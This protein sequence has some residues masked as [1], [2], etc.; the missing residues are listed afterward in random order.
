MATSSAFAL[1]LISNRPAAHLA[2][3]MNLF[4]PLIGSWDMDIVYYRSDGGVK[5][6]VRGEWHFTWALEGRAVE[7]VWITPP[8]SERRAIDPA[9]GEYGV[10]LRFFDASID[11]WRSTWHG[12]VH[13][14]VWPFI[15]RARGNDIVLER[16]DEDGALAHWTF[17]NICHERFEWRAEI[18]HDGGRT[19]R[20][21]QEMRARRQTPGE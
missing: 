1:A 19:W 13:G 10:T 5:S 11:A 20:L 21:E 14:I 3:K 2:D 8:R 15:G 17:S 12:P 16:L 18:S 4:A 6:A 9:P 7:D